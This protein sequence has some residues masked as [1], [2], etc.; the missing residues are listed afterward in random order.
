MGGCGRSL[1]GGAGH[2]RWY[3]RGTF[4]RIGDFRVLYDVDQQVRIVA[5][6]RIGEKRGNAFYIR[7]QQEDI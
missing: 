4:G 1:R 2:L 7:G 3:N 5:I 6:K